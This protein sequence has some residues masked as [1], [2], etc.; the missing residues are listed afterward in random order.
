MVWDGVYVP[1]RGRIDPEESKKKKNDALRQKQ[2]KKQKREKEPLSQMTYID[3]A[4]LEDMMERVARRVY[5]E[6]RKEDLMRETAYLLDRK[7]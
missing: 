4:A 2:N 1:Q 3:V 5:R 7:G 6:C